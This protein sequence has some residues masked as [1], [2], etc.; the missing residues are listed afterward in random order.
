MRQA[1]A[2][3]P[4]RLLLSIAEQLRQPLTS[5]ARQAELAQLTGDV[6]LVHNHGIRTQATA[7]LS[8]L[9]SYL[10]GL[11]LLRDPDQLQLQPISLSSL[12]A[13]TWHE[14]DAFAK[15]YNVE[16]ELITG[17]KYGPVMGHP[18]GLK[19]AMLSVGFALVEAQAEWAE[20]K[21]KVIS[22]AVHRT[23][24][25]I[26]AGVYGQ[27][28]AVNASTWRTA[29]ELCG[30]ARQPFV[31]LPGASAAGLFVADAILRSMN[32]RLRVGRYQH[33]GG[34]AATLQP[35]QQLQFV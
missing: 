16:L 15:H 30:Q 9:D 18:A 1:Q 3:Q 4:D 12:L 23:P 19:A 26:V 29:L 21:H 7:A 13:D 33:Q 8:L 35:S 27:Q 2:A 24:H 17:G 28:P 34:L 11:D 10:L 25:G 32:S 6:Q 14:L 20:R 5:I 22:L 31:G